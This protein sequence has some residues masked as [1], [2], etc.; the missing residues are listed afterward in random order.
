MTPGGG[1]LTLNS[2]RWNRVNDI[3]VLTGRFKSNYGLNPTAGDVLC[4]LPVPAKTTCRVAV[5]TNMWRQG[6]DL[7]FT[8]NSQNV[9]IVGGD[10]GNGYPAG[11]EV[12]FSG[13][14]VYVG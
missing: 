6:L 14:T 10:T 13:V 11:T 9:T 4:R 2:A 8:A 1:W 7:Q 12:W 5:L 3:L